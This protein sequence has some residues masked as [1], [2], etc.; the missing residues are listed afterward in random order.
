MEKGWEAN[1]WPRGNAVQA[2]DGSRRRGSQRRGWE[3]MSSLTCIVYI[4]SLHKRKGKMLKVSTEWL[5]LLQAGTGGVANNLRATDHC[6]GGGKQAIVDQSQ[7]TAITRAVAAPLT[8][9]P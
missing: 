7:A 1:P 5:R 9:T 8:A 6:F 4:F 3:A 2:M